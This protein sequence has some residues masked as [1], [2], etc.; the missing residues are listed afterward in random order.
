MRAAPGSDA[1]NKLHQLALPIRTVALTED[2]FCQRF[3]E[4]GVSRHGRIVSN[5]E[6]LPLLALPFTWQGAYEVPPLA[7]SFF[8]RS[9]TFHRPSPSFPSNREKKIR[10]RAYFS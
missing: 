2:D 8:Q 5:S 3:D 1:V 6:V 10:A 7:V 4:G 9:H